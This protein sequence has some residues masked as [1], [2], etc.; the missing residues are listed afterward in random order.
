MPVAILSALQ[1]L[2]SGFWAFASSRMGQILIAFAVA[3]VWSGWRHDDYWKAV[4]ASEKAA[5]QAAYRAEVKRQEQAAIEIAVAATA[6]AEEDS[7]LER[8]LR[9]QIEAFNSQESQNVAVTPS[10]PGAIRGRAVIDRDFANVLQRLDATARRP[11][12]P[13]RSAR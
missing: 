4:M 10:K 5:A 1:W 11:V 13:S 2:G 8:E 7:A 9:A 12:K 6:R 3:W